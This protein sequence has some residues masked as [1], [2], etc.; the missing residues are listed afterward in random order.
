MYLQ[1]GHIPDFVVFCLFVFCLFV[2]L[3]FVY[4]FYR[5]LV[6]WFVCLFVCLLL[7]WIS[8]VC[9]SIAVFLIMNYTL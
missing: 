1:S 2:C 3:Y 6:R 4:L 7:K 5:S 8:K 9:E